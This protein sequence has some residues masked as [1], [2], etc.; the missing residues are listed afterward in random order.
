MSPVSNPND[1]VPPDAVERI[2]DALADRVADRVTAR[3][4][5]DGWI[6]GAD[7][8]AAHISA[9]RSRVYALVAAKRIPVT[10]DGG[11]LV[12]RRSELDAWL[13]EGGARRP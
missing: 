5:A 6:R 12:A 2:L 4:A 11:A 1:L 3:L 13:R 8:I 7:A 10:R 9:P